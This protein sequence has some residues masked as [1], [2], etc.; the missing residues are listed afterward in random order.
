MSKKFTK[1]VADWLARGDDDLALVKLIL[2]KGSSSSNPACFHAQQAAEK[3]L[4]GF[5]AYHDLHL[6]KIHDL[7]IL[8]EDCK[9]IVPSFAEL[10]GYASFLNQ[11]YAESRYPDDY[12]AFSRADAERGLEAA[13][14]IK[15]FVRSVVEGSFSM[16]GFGPIIAIIAVATLALILGGGWYAYQN[17][18]SNLKNQNGVAENVKPQASSG[19]E[20]VQGGETKIDTSASSTLPTADWKTYRSEE[21]GFEV[22]YPTF[23]NEPISKA[24]SYDGF[25]SVRLGHRAANENI[26]EDFSVTVFLNVV[27]N[28]AKLSINDWFKNIVHGVPESNM[29]LDTLPSQWTHLEVLFPLPDSYDA[30][31]IC[32]HYLMSPSQKFGIV[33][34]GGSETSRVEKY[35]YG[36]REKKE[37][38]YDQIL[39]TFK[40]F[41]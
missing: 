2:E 17:K 24:E 28:P 29:K 20:V 15:K 21:Y 35:G 40:E 10:H 13:E 18:K 3:Y 7:V 9:N 19:K 27:K 34:C 41:N 31:P 1:Y 22:K 25:D 36:T 23:G 5:L 39:T 11:F 8:L 16:T 4:K 33:F 6:R 30:G 37:I 38:L 26:S 14:R 12:T 32:S